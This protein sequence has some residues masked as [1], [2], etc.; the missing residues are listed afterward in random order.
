MGILPQVSEWRLGNR[1]KSGYQVD[2]PS[3]IVRQNTKGI[4]EGIH[5]KASYP[6]PRFLKDTEN[7]ESLA[8][9]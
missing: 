1:G 2:G 8:K 4:S 6:R 9:K 7:I 5:L 3:E